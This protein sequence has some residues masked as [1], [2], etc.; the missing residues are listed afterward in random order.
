[1]KKLSITL[2]AILFFILIPAFSFGQVVILEEPE[3]EEGIPPIL[4]EFIEEGAEKELENFRKIFGE[5]WTSIID[6]M[7]AMKVGDIE[8]FFREGKKILAITPRILPKFGL[9]LIFPI[10]QNYPGPVVI[11]PN[12]VEIDKGD[13]GITVGGQSVQIKD[14]GA[15]DIEDILLNLSVSGYDT[16]KL[17][18]K[19]LIKEKALKII[20]EEIE[21]RTELPVKLEKG[22]LFVLDKEKK[23]EK[24]IKKLS[25]HAVRELKSRYKR[26]EA[27][28]MAL[29]MKDDQAVYTVDGYI[30]G[31]ILWIIPITFDVKGEYDAEKGG[32]IKVDKPWWEIFVF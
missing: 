30:R 24:K 28:E 17:E 26:F 29:E 18:V 5:E 4:P 14:L 2:F 12:E 22:K 20:S 19:N 9:D 25:S 8:T 31:R 10:N 15:L 16:D 7:E 13:S 3:E 1:M 23:K 27:A 32:I 11:D 6:V 21:T